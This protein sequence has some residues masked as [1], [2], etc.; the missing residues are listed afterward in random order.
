[1]KIYLETRRSGYA[2]DQLDKSI[3]VGE[4]VEFLTDNY[5]EDDEIILSNDKGY[6]FGEIWLDNF[7][8]TEDYNAYAEW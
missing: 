3:T 6:T 8:E 2:P 1:M 7:R 4:L 5:C